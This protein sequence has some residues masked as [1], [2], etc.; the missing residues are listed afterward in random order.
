MLNEGSG[1]IVF[2]NGTS[3]SGKT[4][5]AAELTRT[6]FGYEYMGVDEYLTRDRNLDEQL[7]RQDEQGIVKAATDAIYN[8]HNSIAARAAAGRNVVADHVLWDSELTEHAARTLGPYHVLLVGVYCP[9]DI[10]KEREKKRGDRI[11]GIVQC[12]FPV[13]HE[14]KL[15]DVTVDT[16]VL[17]PEQCATEIIDAINSRQYISRPT[18]EKFVVPT[19]L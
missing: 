19:E 12:Q 3:S 17:R 2:L 11:L 6:L 8:F 16:S 1:L 15:Y 14:G 9:L 10:A 7:Q 5:I 4:S 13:V 18:R